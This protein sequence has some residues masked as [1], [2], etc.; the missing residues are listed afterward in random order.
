MR[1]ILED[2][3]CKVC[4]FVNKYDDEHQLKLSKF[5]ASFIIELQ[6]EACMVTKLQ[7]EKSLVESGEALRFCTTFFKEFLTKST[8]EKLSRALKAGKA[9]RVVTLLPS[10]KRTP[11][12]L[13]KHFN[14]AGLTNYVKY[15]TTQTLD[16]RGEDT[17]EALEEVF[18]EMASLEEGA[19]AIKMIQAQ[20]ALSNKDVVTCIMGKL[21]DTADIVGKNRAK[22]Y[23]KYIVGH[24]EMLTEFTK[25]KSAETQLI[26]VMLEYVQEDADL[27]RSFMPTCLALYEHETNTLGEGAII[28]WYDAAVE[29]GDEDNAVYVAY[30]KPF[31]EWLKETPAE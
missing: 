4:M 8:P 16:R 25:G 15:L 22:E 11:A 30:M 2:V 31:V 14:E 21:H 6:A 5:M 12:N 18:S 3:L 13:F 23:M 10:T 27:E 9:D 29:I 24:A 19:E 17:I 28:D 20:Q 26:K 1:P 7:Q